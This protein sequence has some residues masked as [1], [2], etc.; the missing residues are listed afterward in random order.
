MLTVQ[1]IDIG[2]EG[3]FVFALFGLL[4]VPVAGTT[5]TLSLPGFLHWRFGGLYTTEYVS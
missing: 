2:E 1:V 3:R 4:L 5:D